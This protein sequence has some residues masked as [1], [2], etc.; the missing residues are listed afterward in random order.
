MS[1]PPTAGR[2][3]ARKRPFLIFVLLVA[4]LVVAIAAAYWWTAQQSPAAP[5]PPNYG[6]IPVA[7]SVQTAQ[8]G[9]LQRD[10]HALGTI[11]PLAQV[12]L[13]SQVD[14]ELLRLHY[15]EGQPV[16]KGELLAEIDARPFQTALA[17]AQGELARTQ[18]LL[19]NAQADLNRYR[20]LAR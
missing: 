5:A 4:A 3:F 8:V 18:A 12:V 17:A 16:K 15:T 1:L 9:P 6:Q 2:S 19:D 7:V 11:T 20:K 13:R 10:L 14:G